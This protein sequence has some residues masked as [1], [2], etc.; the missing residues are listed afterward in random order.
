MSWNYRLVKYANGSGFGVHEVHYDA[1]GNP[2]SMT[3]EPATF[4]GEAPEDIADALL[5]ARAD[6]ARRGIFEQPVEWSTQ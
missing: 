1:N 3:A 2:Q 4:V 5:K 6:V